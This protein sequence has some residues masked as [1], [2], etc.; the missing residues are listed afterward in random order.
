[1]TYIG[2]LIDRCS[3]MGCEEGL[4]FVS[5]FGNK[6]VLLPDYY[7]RLAAFKS[8]PGNKISPNA[9]I[10]TIGQYDWDYF[11]STKT[12]QPKQT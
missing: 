1:M 2:C 6:N 11:K 4:D 9:T 3:V 12:I 7:D 10:E 5:Q 8:W